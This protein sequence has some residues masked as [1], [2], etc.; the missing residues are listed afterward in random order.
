VKARAIIINLGVFIGLVVPLSI[1]FSRTTFHLLDHLGLISLL[2]VFSSMAYPICLRGTKASLGFVREL[3][4]LLFGLLVAFSISELVY[5]RQMEPIH[6]DFGESVV[7]LGFF[8]ACWGM[9]AI[10]SYSI[11]FLVSKSV[12]NWYAKL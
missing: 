9:L 5:Y 4:I 3:L 8:V 11:G 12:S 2:C 1:V 10:L 6:H 7:V